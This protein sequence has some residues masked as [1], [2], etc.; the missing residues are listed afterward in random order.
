[1]L[2]AHRA[3]HPCAADRQT[4]GGALGGKT[5]DLLPMPLSQPC[6]GES[7]NSKWN[8]YSTR[9]GA[10]APGALALQATSTFLK[11]TSDGGVCLSGRS[12]AAAKPCPRAFPPLGASDRDA[13]LRAQADTNQGGG[14]LSKAASTIQRRQPVRRPVTP[15][16]SEGHRC[17]PRPCA[18]LGRV[19]RADDVE[20]S[21]C[22]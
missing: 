16:R 9:Q 7:S 22:E 10:Q 17:L 18:S 12:G 1:M 14:P 8:G 2:R 11:P 19:T 13:S 3:T 15:T 6:T 20:R 5:L 4:G 21:Q